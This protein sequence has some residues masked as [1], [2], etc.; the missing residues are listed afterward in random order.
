MAKKQ[1]RKQKRT[2]DRYLPMV[3]GVGLVLL[4]FILFAALR[5]SDGA[6][7]ASEET[8]PSRSVVPMAVNY[9]A[10]ELA[11][12][13]VDGKS[14]SLADFR[15]SVVLVNNWA[16]WCPPCKAEMPSLQKYYAA[17]QA[18]GFVLIAVNAGDP[19]EAVSAFMKDFGLTFHVWLDPKGEALRAFRNGSL[20][21]SYV[22]DRKGT[23]RYAWTGEISLDMLEK[24]VTPVIQEQ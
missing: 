1:K 20:P 15:G 4:G 3:I 24:F 22:I 19:Q 2:D 13:T 23:T 11:L 21:N 16:T 8:L 17:H 14:E 18:E 6:A 7:S 9:P 10:P 12:Q 5:K